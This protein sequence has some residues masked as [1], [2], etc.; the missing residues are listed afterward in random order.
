VAGASNLERV[1]QVVL[2]GGGGH[3]SDVLGAIEGTPGMEAVGFLDDGSPD[4]R[5]FEGRDL[6]HLGPV[7]IL[8]TLDSGIEYLVAIGD[9]KTRTAVWERIRGATQRPAVLVH[10]AVDRGQRTEVGAGAVVLPG[11]RLSPGARIG[12]HCHVSYT[13]A[14]GHDAVVGSFSIVMPAAIVSGD[15]RIGS[16]VLVGSNATVL[17]G[18]SIGDGATI[19]AGAVVTRDVPPGVTVIGVP[20]RPRCGE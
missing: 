1:S 8:A 20:A 5:R 11:A 17:E 14:V 7:A 3:A 18:L 16:G 13:A 15:V 6:P 2:L 4:L 9:P 10:P 19:G 12:D